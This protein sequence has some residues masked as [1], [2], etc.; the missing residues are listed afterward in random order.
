MLPRPQ[1]CQEVVRVAAAKICLPIADEKILERRK[2]EP[3][4]Y[5]LAV[6]SLAQSP[7]GV[8]AAHR[9][10]ATRRRGREPAILPCRIGGQRRLNPLE[11]D[12]IMRR[13]LRGAADR[14][15][16]FYTVREQCPPMKCLLRP[17]REPIDEMNALDPEHL[18]HQALLDAHI[19]G[20]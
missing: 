2:A 19:V 6:E 13:C 14:S 4:P 12:E 20:H 3:A 9:L 8:D 5:L 11:K 10:K 16:A 15:D 7:S 1:H 18:L 17:H